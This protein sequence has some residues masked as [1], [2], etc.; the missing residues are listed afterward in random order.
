MLYLILILA[1]LIGGIPFGLLMGKVK[2]IDIREHGSGNIGATNT[3]RVLGARWGLSCFILDALKGF[4]PVFA[5]SCLG[6]PDWLPVAAVFAAVS[7]HVWSPYLSFKGGKGVATSAGALLGVAALPVTC[8]LVVWGITFKVSRYVSLASI[9][10]AITLPIFGFLLHFLTSRTYSPATLGLLVV[11]GL[12][13]VIR[14]RSNIQ[15]LLNGT[16][17]KMGSKNKNPETSPEPS[18]TQSS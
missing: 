10:A 7:G 6:G 16:E 15:R 13:T 3:W 18:N 11:L 5:A 8:A 17:S 4:G 2:G 12:V 14:H 1:Y 9:L